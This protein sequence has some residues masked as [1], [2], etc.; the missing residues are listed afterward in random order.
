MTPASTDSSGTSPRLIVSY[1][2]TEEA[3]LY[4]QA[5]RG[6]R[7]GGINDPINLPL[8]SATD[9]L[10]FGNQLELE[11]REDLELRARGRRRSGSTG[12]SPST[13]SAFY[14]DIKDLQAT[15]TAGTCSSRVVFNVPTA[16]SD[17]VEVELFAQAQ[18][19]LGLR[20][21]GDATSMPS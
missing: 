2:P 19:E 21:V 12:A 10:V 11:G 16:R 9:Q 3:Q 1:K 8:C 13:S 5:A 6:F 20:H 7:L 14:S 15:T 17:G 4:A 18:R